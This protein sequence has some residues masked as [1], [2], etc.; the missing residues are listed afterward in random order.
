ME[1]YKALEAWKYFRDGWVQAI[2]HRKIEGN[3]VVMRADV[4]PSYR[5]T[6]EPHKPWVALKCSGD[7]LASHCNCMAG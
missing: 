2:T 4:R 7:V 5:T 1:N 3:I 6:E